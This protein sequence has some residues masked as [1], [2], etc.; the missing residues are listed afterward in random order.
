MLDPDLEFVSEAED[1]LE[2]VRGDLAELLQQ[3]GDP[4][5]VA[6]LVH[7]L[8]RRLHTL[9]GLC[10]AVGLDQASRLSHLLETFLDAFRMGRM[11][12]GD[13]FLEAL[14]ES[15]MLLGGLVHQR[16][17]AIKRCDRFILSLVGLLDKSSEVSSTLSP[18]STTLDPDLFKSLTGFECYRLQW[19]LERSKPVFLI[20]CCLPLE[21]FQSLLAEFE[22]LLRIHGELIATMPAGLG[23][24]DAV[25]FH[26]LFCGAL[27]EST[28]GHFPA[29]YRLRV[30][31]VNLR[32]AMN[33]SSD[34]SSV[35]PANSGTSQV[36]RVDKGRLDELLEI[37][38]NLV[39]EQAQLKRF[40]QQVAKNGEDGS[41]E[42]VE[43]SFQELERGLLRLQRSLNDAR[44][45]PI[46]FLFQRMTRVVRNA[47]RRSGNE[48]RL[49]MRGDEV[50]LDRNVLEQL[51]DPLLHLVR[52]AI[53][54]GIESP[55]QR[56]AAG[57]S[58][59]GR[60]VLEAGRRGGQIVIEVRDDGRGI[61]LQ[62]VRSKGCDLGL[63]NDGADYSD[64][65]LY[66][67][68]FQP[69][70]S[71]R[72]KAT[73]LSGRGVGMD[74]VRSQM[75]A[76]GGLAA[77]DSRF[78]EGTRV[79][80]TLPVHK[81]IMPVLVVNIADRMYAMAL[82]GVRY[83]EPFEEDGGQ[84]RVPDGMP[85]LETSL[86]LF[87]L[88]RHLRA[89]AGSHNGPAYLVV[90]GLGDRQAGI[91]VDGLGGRRESVIRPFD[92]LLKPVPGFSAVA[93]LIDTGPVLLLDLGHLIREAGRQQLPAE[94][95]CAPTRVAGTCRA[96]LAAGEN[97]PPVAGIG[98]GSSPNTVA[99][100]GAE[101][102]T[103][104]TGSSDFLSFFLEGHEY[105]LDITDV[106]EIIE[107]ADWI[108]VPHVSSFI[109]GILIWRDH[110]VPVLDAGFRI[111]AAHAREE[112]CG[113]VIVSRYGDRTVAVM[114]ERLGQ[115]FH[116]T[117][118][119]KIGM[120]EH[121]PAHDCLFLSRSVCRDG[122]EISVLD[123]AAMLDFRTVV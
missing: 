6:D 2:A 11:Q 89:S 116:V 18:S 56:I 73:E 112:C 28:A 29:E 7:R 61:K 88:R 85:G 111:G 8:F 13:S 95:S 50:P 79:S 78:G 38:K 52:N 25:D 17:D 47:S 96:K 97:A 9:K 117:E 118:E 45:M 64:Q 103:S 65:E 31:A 44:M 71:T 98:E 67:L 74:V 36:I 54:H 51:H 76:L 68:L 37:A 122:R 99:E 53:D 109:A 93:E 102:M 107:D 58:R 39:L 106:V 26:L 92:E 24:A 5:A 16:P 27:P 42:L 82:E 81:T 55:E 105:A 49:D 91:I 59:E 43:R 86:P 21:S 41:K 72:G 94:K 83:V 23:T 34:A 69:G 12:L 87:D 115:I 20:S 3:H 75:E 60:I 1:L 35:Q 110:I 57:K 108:T 19:C 15:V 14:S 100:S 4:S 119:G 114:V 121:H 22:Q 66:D 48:V 30:R 113:T 40:Y 63:I 120:Q 70:F 10:A 77:I 32:G 101:P 80:L 84:S 104:A 33:S 123:L 46:R 62:D 90:I